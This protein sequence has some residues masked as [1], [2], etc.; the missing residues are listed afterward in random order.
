MLKTRTYKYK[1]LKEIEA[2]IESGKHNIDFLIDNISALRILGYKL[3]LPQQLKF[4]H[5]FHD[6]ITIDENL[7]STKAV[8]TKVRSYDRE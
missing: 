4:K 7:P 8:V 6:V 5:A 1:E 3:I 2:I